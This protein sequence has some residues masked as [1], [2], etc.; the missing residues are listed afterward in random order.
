[1][2]RKMKAIKTLLLLLCISSFAVSQENEKSLSA[3]LS[4]GTFTIPNGESYIETYL[5]VEANSVVFAPVEVHQYQANVEVSLLFMQND[6]VKSFAKYA[7]NSPLID[8]PERT[9]FGILDQQRFSLPDGEYL[10]ILEISDLNNPAVAPFRSEETILLDFP[11]NQVQLSAIQ[12]IERFEKSSA[13]SII[14]KN[15]YDLIPM[16]YAFYPASNHQ[17]SFYTEVYFTDLVLGNDTKFIT[18][19]F[20]ES[21]ESKNK[22][23]GFFYRKRMDARP[24]NILMSNIDISELPSGN[25]FLTVEV[26][27]QQNELLASNRLFF[28]RSNPNVEYQ[29]MD[30]ASVSTSN[31]FVSNYNNLDTL[32]EF[33]HCIA[34]LASEAERDYAYNL[35]K[36]EDVATMQRFFYNFWQKRNNLNPQESW[37]NYLTEV[38]KVNAAY[39]TLTKKGYDADRGRVYL[40]YGPPNHIVEAYNESGAYPYEIW[41]YYTLGNQRNKRFVFATKDMVTN[42]FMLIHSD[43]IGELSN[44]RWQLEIYKRTWDPHSIDQ[45]GP[46]D[47]FGN[48]AYDFYKNPR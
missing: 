37:L 38:N 25:Y 4:Y 23:Q 9:N 1:M 2:S 42:D 36:T 30:I 12:L 18:S 5:A 13:E 3:F 14:T 11:K 21:F 6:S 41:H 19:Y 47:V 24:V 8:N 44:Y 27:N 33:L 48:R 32:R 29:L 22:M 35:A 15:G 34:P 16:P 39:K 26:R 10:M 40:K 28:Q 31:T 46:E 20:I 45:T 7:L 43:A 17:L